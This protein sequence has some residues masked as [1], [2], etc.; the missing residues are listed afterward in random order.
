[1]QAVHKLKSFFSVM[2]S[3]FFAMKD[4]CL[5]F[6]KKVAENLDEC[7][8]SYKKSLCDEISLGAAVSGG[9]DSVSLLVSLKKILPQNISLKVVT[10][11]HNIRSEKESAGDASFVENLCRSLG[12]FCVRFDVERG[13]IFS[14]AKEN[15]TS[16][17]DAARKIRYEKFAEFARN[18]K[19]GFICL[20]HNKNDQIETV[21]MRF[22]QGSPV[23]G[24]IPRERGIF[25]R[26]LLNIP[27]C[28]IEKY[29]SEKKIAF[30]TDGTNFDDSILRNRFRRKI[31][32]F[33]D[34]EISGWQNAVFRLSKKMHSDEEF[35]SRT[36]EESLQKIDAEFA[37]DSVSFCAEKFF[38]LH[39]SIRV[40]VVFKILE[41]I[42]AASRVPFEFVHS[43]FCGKK[44][45]REKKSDCC[46][47]EFL[48]SDGTILIQKKQK[49]ATEKYFFVIMATD[50]DFCVGGRRFSVVSC[51][52]KI[53]IRSGS[54]EIV[55][56]NLGFPFVFRSRAP[57][58]SVRCAD[59]SYRSA[60][61]ILDDW[62][63]GEKR[64]SIP[65]VQK[66]SV[67]KKNPRQEIRCIWGS[68]FGFKDW[69]V[70]D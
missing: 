3:F 70:K 59:G 63:A 27:R 42:G 24:G 39:E 6:E 16:V 23:L 25:L 61:K 32:P 64:N 29:L 15:G 50:G 35:L 46:G 17:E 45:L 56:E 44:I 9:A 43:L 37:Q 53:S 54:C 51:G 12:V 41:K 7:L 66:I 5:D 52:K 57:G 13:K 18:E 65:F 33:L 48:H 1:M 22:F 4:F 67:E 20:A 8:S 47:I 21:A 19:I 55:L 26:P 14:L 34:E 31:I 60:S 36:A 2:D 62:K 38:L 68:L 49:V 58:D 69:I 10:V 30:R 40:R 28:E 11:N